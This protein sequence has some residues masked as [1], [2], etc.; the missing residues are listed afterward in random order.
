MIK[1][2]SNFKTIKEDPKDNMVL[3][4]AYDGRAEY[5]VSGDKHLQKLKKFK[6]TRVVSPR[7]FMTIITKKFG[8]LVVPKR[9]I[10]RE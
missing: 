9:E 2:Q 10:T 3:N 5:I 1:V 4:P 8:E 7:E 6:N